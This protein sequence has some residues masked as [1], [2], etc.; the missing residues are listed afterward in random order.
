MKGA[1][2][3]SSG[4]GAQ[5]VYRDKKGRKLDMLN[6]FMKQQD[7]R[8]GKEVIDFFGTATAVGLEK[9]LEFFVCGDLVAR[10][11]DGVF[12]G[13]ERRGRGRRGGAC[14]L[15]F[16]A[17]VAIILGKLLPASGKGGL[18]PSTLVGGAVR[19]GAAGTCVVSV[20]E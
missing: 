3:T 15:P 6:E 5:T 1:D 12:R 16:T 14:F 8:A 4:Q 19:C 2:K 13:S 18:L 9:P 11:S 7:A 20:I 17:V 10:A